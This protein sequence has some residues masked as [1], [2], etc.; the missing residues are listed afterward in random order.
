MEDKQW[1]RKELETKQQ[2]KVS[3][4]VDHN[5]DDELVR[6]T[7]LLSNLYE[8]CNAVVFEPTKFKE[9]KN[10]DT[11]PEAMKEESKMIEKND[12]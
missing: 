7:R 8:R 6:G 5:I 9:A 4:N 10:D 1:K 3:Q 2:S 11:W 12:T